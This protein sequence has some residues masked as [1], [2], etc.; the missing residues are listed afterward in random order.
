MVTESHDPDGVESIA[1]RFDSS[2]FRHTV[3]RFASGV[4]VLTALHDGRIH[5]MTANAI[6]SVSL[7]PPLVL[8]SLDNRSHKHRSLPQAGRFG[9]SVLSEGQ[10]QLSN[11]FAGR[12]LEGV[13]IHIV[14]RNEI[15]L[16]DGA[17]AYFVVRVMDVHPTGDHTLY[18]AL[19]EFLE[20]REAKPS[21]F[22]AGRYRQLRENMTSSPWAQ[23][24]HSL[25]L[26]GCI[27]PP[28]T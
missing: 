26:I 14:T 16:L 25:F 3:G 17:L 15:P 9:I 20:P 4:T 18:V 10:E 27:D 7:E 8:I 11:H 19:V 12:P 1:R 24:D 5:G 2:Q 22:Y 23:D 28:S 6:V 13:P 21:I